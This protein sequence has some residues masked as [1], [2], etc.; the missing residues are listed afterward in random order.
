M[1]TQITSPSAAVQTEL[2]K[3]LDCFRGDRLKSLAD[4]DRPVVTY[5]YKNSNEDFTRYISLDAT[6]LKKQVESGQMTVDDVPKCMYGMHSALMTIFRTFNLLP[7]EDSESNSSEI[8][9]ENS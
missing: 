4:E 5:E 8:P 7:K 6:Y 2:E 1:T 9:T 3:I